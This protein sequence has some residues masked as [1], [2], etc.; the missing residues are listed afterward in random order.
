[1][2]AK[3]NPQLEIGRNSSIYFAIGLNLMLLLTWQTLEYKTFEKANVDIGIMNVETVFEEEIPIINTNTPPPPP[4]SPHRS[5]SIPT[6]VSAS[7]GDPA[8]KGSSSVDHQSPHYIF[9]NY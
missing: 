9:R 1:M 6:S 4:P 5:R 8:G 2:E 3:K 7:P